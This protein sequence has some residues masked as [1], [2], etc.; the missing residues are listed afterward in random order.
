MTKKAVRRK[1]R[2]DRLAILM[3][4]VVLLIVTVNFLFSLILKKDKLPESLST[5][6]YHMHEIG[7]AGR[8]QKIKKNYIVAIH[9]P[10]VKN[11]TINQDIAMTINSEMERFEETYKDYK[12][13]GKDDKMMLVID[14]ET[15][16]VGDQ[17]MSVVFYKAIGNEISQLDYQL[18]LTKTYNLKTG[19]VVELEEIFKGNYLQKIAAIARSEIR[20]QAT[21]TSLTSSELFFQGTTAENNNYQHYILKDNVLRIYF[22]AG[23]VLEGG[24]S[25]TQVDIQISDLSFYLKEEFPSIV[26]IQPTQSD[27]NSVRYI[28]PNK[29]IIAL[30][31]DDGPSRAS[32]QRI[33][34]VLSDNNSSATFFVVGSRVDGHSDLITAIVAG[35]NE[36]GNHTY[37][38]KDLTTLSEEEIL[39]EI[40]SVNE[41]ISKYTDSTVYLVRPV[42]GRYNQLVRDVSAYPFILWTV[43]TRDWSTRDADAV[44]DAVME[45]AKDGAIILCHDLYETTAEAAERFI[46]DLIAQGYQL[47]TVSELAE[48]HGIVLEPGEI[49]SSL[50]KGE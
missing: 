1:L 3:L 15:T 50:P 42:S 49:Y 9:Y 2:I 32:T 5:S 36:I 29:P 35:G 16:V 19:N 27:E 11:K 39:A 48:Y 22:E 37:S 30:T 7:N 20:K 41:A 34:D 12:L 40:N 10:S 26:V 23:Q 45:G 17:Y 44:Y 47:V 13:T 25:A 31:F 18:C 6:R 8:L 38:H 24:T 43:D 4:A 28:D 33:L 14:Y 21:D 46:P